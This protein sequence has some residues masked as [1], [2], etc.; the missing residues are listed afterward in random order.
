MIAKRAIKLVIY[1]IN[2]ATY[3]IIHFK[4]VSYYFLFFFQGIGLL[5][6]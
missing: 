2:V 3:L 4:D 1:V 5:S 6:V